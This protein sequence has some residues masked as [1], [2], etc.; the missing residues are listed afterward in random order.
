MKYISESEFP[1]GE[2]V[3][4]FGM[5]EDWVAP[6]DT[7]ILLSTDDPDCPEL[8][9]IRGPDGLHRT[10]L[11][12][13]EIAGVTLQQAKVWLRAAVS[14]YAVRVHR[15]FDENT[16]ADCY[17]WNVRLAD[18]F[19]AGGYCQSETEAQMDAA[20]WVCGELDRAGRTEQPTLLAA[21]QQIL[22]SVDKDG[23][24]IRSITGNDVA[25]V[26]QA[27]AAATKS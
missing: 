5:D 25:L 23:G 20:Q 9:V 18:R 2:A 4:R 10:W 15:T 7:C 27:V 19:V 1:R 11:E 26:R 22:A 8:L 16:G 12:L 21:C 6:V 24:S 13:D 17:G 3:V 14:D